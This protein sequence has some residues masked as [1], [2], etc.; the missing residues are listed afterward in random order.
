MF[1]DGVS[2]RKKLFLNIANAQ[3][4]CQKNTRSICYKALG[5]ASWPVDSNGRA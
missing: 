2:G 4:I 5:K 3:K 1:S